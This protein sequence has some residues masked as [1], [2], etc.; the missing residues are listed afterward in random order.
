MQLSKCVQKGEKMF[1]V[2][3]RYLHTFLVKCNIS[4]GLR[5]N[6]G[7]QENN[8]VEELENALRLRAFTNNANN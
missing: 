8:D 6:G 1:L 7:L 3:E 5:S 2:I 4:G